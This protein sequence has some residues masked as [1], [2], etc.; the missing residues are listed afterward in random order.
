MTL[1]VL[2]TCDYYIGYRLL[3]AS[4]QFLEIAL[5]QSHYCLIRAHKKEADEPGQFHGTAGT[6]GILYCC[7]IQ[8]A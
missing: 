3:L 5:C 1:L 4:L 7:Q 8:R 6:I 2:L